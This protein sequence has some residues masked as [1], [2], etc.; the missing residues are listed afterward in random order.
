MKIDISKKTYE[1]KW[2][3]Y[4]DCE[5]LLEPYP[6]GLND[7]VVSQ[8]QK[9]TIPGPQR[10]EIFMDSVKDF[11]GIADANGV[12]IKCTEATK[13]LIFN[14][15]LGGIAGFVYQY[16]SIFEAKMRVELENLQPGQPGSL[17]PK[18]N[19]AEIADEPEKMDS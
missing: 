12:D 4:N 1:A 15:N 14:H 10:K 5:L 2:V 16:N 6:V 7:L 17:T 11:K 3:E 13:E 18:V 8:D 9:M 19:P